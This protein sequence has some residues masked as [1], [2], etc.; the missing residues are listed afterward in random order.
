[1][2]VGG[3]THIFIK[4]NLVFFINKIIMRSISNSCQRLIETIFQR[5]QQQYGHKRTISLQDKINMYRYIQEQLQR[6][7]T[8]LS[9]SS[10][11]SDIRNDYLQQLGRLVRTTSTPTT[12]RFR[13]VFLELFLNVIDSFRETT[14]RRSTTTTTTT[15]PRRAR[16]RRP[17]SITTHADIRHH[18]TNNLGVAAT[19]VGG[20]ILVVGTIV[21]LA[22]RSK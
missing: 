19:T 21:L 10:T 12:T 2:F 1:M 3:N 4:K 15:G 6:L 20:L 14:V 7:F 17:S 22:T 18:N 16:T 9:R 11:L 8:R 13:Q 5:L